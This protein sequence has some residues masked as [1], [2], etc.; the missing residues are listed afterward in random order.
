MFF[1]TRIM[2][3]QQNRQGVQPP[4]KT[5]MGFQKKNKDILKTYLVI[6]NYNTYMNTRMHMLNH[7]PEDLFQL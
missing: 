7:S 5:L 1:K 6:L 2:Y 4:K 3:M